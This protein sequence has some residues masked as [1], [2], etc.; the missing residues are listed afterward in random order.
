MLGQPRSTQRH[1]RKVPDEEEQ[2]VERIVSL[3]SQYGR[4]GYRQLLS[5]KNE[6]TMGTK[7]RELSPAIT[8]EQWVLWHVF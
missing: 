1:V 5:A 3:A 4:Y 7:R 6:P 2:L 8:R